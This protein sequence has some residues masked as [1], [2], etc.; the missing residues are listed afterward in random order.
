MSW[1]KTN[2]FF[3]Y[4]G[5]TII[6][7]GCVFLF[8]GLFMYDIMSAMISPIILGVGLILIV[9]FFYETHKHPTTLATET[10]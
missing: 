6:V 1:L 9:K 3:L 2:F 7:A 10:E 8:A 4:F 5:L